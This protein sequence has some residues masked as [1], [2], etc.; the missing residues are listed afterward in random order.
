MPAKISPL[1]KRIAPATPVTLDLQDATG[2][3][4]KLRFNLCFDYNAA[5][6][7]QE[8][9]GLKLTDASVWKHID[10]P[11]F[12]SVLFWAA[13]LAHHPEYNS[14]EGL[15]AIRS[16]MDEKNSEV[17]VKGCWDAYVAYLPKDKREYM[18][19]LKAQ[20]EAGEKPT[21]DPLNPATGEAPPE[22][23]TGSTSGPSPDTTSGSLSKSS[24][25]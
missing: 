14:D 20:A 4:Y 3:S 10:E 5:A 19:K 25:A 15:E 22:S 21:L 12:A 24:V 11:I 1:K 8:H 6:A 18:E 17:I 7:V 2:P 9:T 16:Y 13:I 23:S